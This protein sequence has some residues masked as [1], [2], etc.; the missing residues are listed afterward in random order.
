MLKAAQMAGQFGEV[1]GNGPPYLCARIE[2][3][4]NLTSRR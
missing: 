3:D 4:G 2:E 1:D